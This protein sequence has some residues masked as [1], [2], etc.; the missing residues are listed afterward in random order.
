MPTK[1]ERENWK[2]FTLVNSKSEQ[3]S[4]VNMGHVQSTKKDL[5]VQ[6]ISVNTRAKNYLT[7]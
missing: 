7:F 2:G 3:V 6:N 1:D 5:K 4:L